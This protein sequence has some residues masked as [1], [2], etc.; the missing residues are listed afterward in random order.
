MSCIVSGRVVRRTTFI[1]YYSESWSN[2][3]EYSELCLGIRE[4]SACPHARRKTRSLSTPKI[5]GSR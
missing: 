3:E 1:L 2:Q 4:A 5:S